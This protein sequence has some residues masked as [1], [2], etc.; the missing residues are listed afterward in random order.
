MHQSAFK[1][2]PNLQDFLGQTLRPLL[3]GRVRVVECSFPK[4]ICDAQCKKV[5]IF[6]VAPPD[7]PPGRNPGYGP[8][9]V[10]LHVHTTC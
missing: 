7:P 8:E 3:L 2:H 6:K 10:S 4:I 5:H 1:E 9:D